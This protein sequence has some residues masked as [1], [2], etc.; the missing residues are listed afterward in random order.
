M[1]IS[2]NS[3]QLRISRSKLEKFYKYNFGLEKQLKNYMLKSYSTK[4]IENRTSI[5]IIQN[6][7]TKKVKK[8]SEFLAVLLCGG[9]ATR[10]KNQPKATMQID[11]LIEYGASVTFLEINIRQ[12]LN[13]E[14]RHSVTIPLLLS[15]DFDTETAIKKHLY[16]NN[17]F[18]KNPKSIFYLNTLSTIRLVP[19]GELIKKNNM[20]NS[21]TKEEL[22]NLPKTIS[23]YKSE[24]Q[25][26]SLVSCGHFIFNQLVAS[27]SFKTILKKFQNVRY[28]VISNCDN[29]GMK[30]YP[31]L[32][33][34]DEL[35][36][37]IVTRRVGS[38]S[39]DV[40]I[41]Q[42][43]KQ[44]IQPYFKYNTSSSKLS[45]TGTMY[46]AINQLLY[47]YGINNPQMYLKNKTTKDLLNK[48]YLVL[49]FVENGSNRIPTVHLESPLCEIS[50]FIS[51]QF[52]YINR[53][54]CFFPFKKITDINSNYLKKV[55]DSI[56][57]YNYIR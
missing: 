42:G 46:I 26:D 9:K 16:E 21:L 3:T 57:K 55:K 30:Y 39:A 5:S 13:Y 50:N 22:Y 8:P 27:K 33:D 40:L 31:S 53:N 51:F 48:Y 15:C 20:V 43:D 2:V 32:L 49:K 47:V 12:L 35:S 7:I 4:S 34:K 45:F 18:G 36:K 28:L 24:K 14:K 1:D 11:H 25:K 17:Y 52:V 54:R 10:F 19:N 23:I 29:L 6:V 56:H 41:K 37:A 44:L 38:E